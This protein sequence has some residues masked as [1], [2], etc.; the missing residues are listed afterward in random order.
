MQFASELDYIEIASGKMR[1]PELAF[2]FLVIA[3][4]VN[5]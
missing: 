1:I 2:Y 3:F 5:L 4:I